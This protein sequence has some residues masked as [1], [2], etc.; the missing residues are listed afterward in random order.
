VSHDVRLRSE[1]QPQ[2]DF[3]L[4]AP[5]AVADPFPL[6][7]LA[8]AAGPVSWNPRHRAWMI[9]G[10]HALADAFRNPLL[11]TG[12]RME[13]FVARQ[14]PERQDALSQA[15][16][17]LKGW[18]LF[19]DPPEHTRLRQ[20]F[21]RSFTPKVM[22][23]LESD[24]RTLCNEL[25]EQLD[26]AS[27]N[28]E[29]L[30][31]VR[32][33]THPFPALVIAQLFG[34]EQSDAEWLQKWSEKFGVVVFGAS[35]RD[36]YDTVVRE[37]G[38]EFYSQMGDVLNER[39]KNP[40]DDLISA[41]LATENTTEG[42]TTVEILGACSMIL[43]AGHETTSSTIGSA[44]ISLMNNRNVAEHIAALPIGADSHPAIE[45]LLRYEAPAKA[46]M[47]R[48]V[49]DHEFHGAHL[50]KDDAVFLMILAANRDPGVFSDPD[51]IK[52]DR[53]PNPH[54]TF[55]LGHHYCLGAP[56]AKLETRIAL[57]ALWKRFPRMQLAG[58]V[59]WKPT[60]ADRS[61]LSIPVVLQP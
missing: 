10:H 33:F 32:E 59:N 39:R 15:M 27:Q 44:T 50:R 35:R 37:A 31:L 47:R 49:E 1:R 45:E 36:D 17:L 26:N 46:M 4:L 38:E 29:T 60:I 6:F 55:G 56:L 11:A 34:V 14:S 25:L 30:D 18:M 61:A 9:T 51:D 22:A 57:P 28:G 21:S 12:G 53:H 42:L 41:L 13:A 19:H 23:R 2:C 54:L 20:P 40:K 43:F 5:D 3:D 52:I 8:H 58:E 48:V 7:R 16:E 24:I